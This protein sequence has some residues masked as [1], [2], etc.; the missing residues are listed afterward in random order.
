MFVYFRAFD[1][2]SNII[3]EMFSIFYLQRIFVT[4]YFINFIHLDIC[5][6]MILHV[7]YYLCALFYMS[8][9]NFCY[10]N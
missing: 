4:Y 10:F 3:C 5:L 2:F 9:S 7:L 1:E 8:R 6:S